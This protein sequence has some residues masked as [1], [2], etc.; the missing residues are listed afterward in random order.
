MTTLIKLPAPEPI[1]DAEGLEVDPGSPEA[2]A[3]KAAMRV[4]EYAVMAALYS[5]DSCR[6]IEQLQTEID[7]VHGL[8]VP[9]ALA[10]LQNAGNVDKHRP[11]TGKA[12][13]YSL[14]P[15]GRRVLEAN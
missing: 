8:R 14:T 6:T 10:L 9:I 5:A 7:D 3:N 2:A 11:P 4:C 13:H 1:P 12:M 15:H